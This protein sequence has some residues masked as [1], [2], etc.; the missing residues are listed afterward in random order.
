MTKI[1]NETA[2]KYLDKKD[3]DI[4]T[5]ALLHLMQRYNEVIDLIPDMQAR[6]AC[7]NAKHKAYEVFKKI[8]TFTTE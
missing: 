1:Q 2:T 4:I 7:E 5:D 6:N 8:N 3:V